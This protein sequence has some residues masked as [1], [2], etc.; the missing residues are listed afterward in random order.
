MADIDNKG[1]LRSSGKIIPGG[2]SSDPSPL[3]PAAAMRSPPIRGIV[4]RPEEV[5]ARSKA[6]GIIE[7]AEQKARELLEDAERQRAL[8]F[9]ETREEALEE[10]AA[11]AATELAKA[12]MQAGSML[13]EAKKE[14]I[15]LA[16]QIA[17]KMIGRDLEREPQLLLEICANAIENLRTAKA[18]LLRV[19]PRDAKLLRERRP[20]LIELIGRSVDIA[21]RDDLEV[22]P[23]GCIVQT[24]FG[25]IDAQLETQ[26]R[27]LRI[28]FEEDALGKA[29]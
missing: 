2:L 15:E 23:G 5:D 11:Q 7:E 1:P 18:M 24:E 28:L 8:V 20:E 26:F 9:Q 13:A 27:A 12:K 6:K 10:A 29:D 22:Q 17:E 21:I 25:T 16:C 19:H 14:L 4:V 3:K